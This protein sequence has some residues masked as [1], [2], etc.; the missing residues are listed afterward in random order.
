MAIVSD[1][2][3][4]C[5]NDILV[6]MLVVMP[7]IMPPH[8]YTS[9]YTLGNAHGYIYDYAHKNIYGYAN[10]YACGYIYGYVY[11]PRLYPKTKP[12]N[13]FYGGIYMPKGVNET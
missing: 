11:D 5:A 4:G 10:N 2:V 7:T 8:S 12:I 1:R 3:Y 6:V 9:I 13:N